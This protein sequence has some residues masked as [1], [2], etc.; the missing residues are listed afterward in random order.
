MGD[1]RVNSKGQLAESSAFTSAHSPP[2]PGKGNDAR[3]PSRC[4]VRGTCVRRGCG[5]RRQLRFEG[6]VSLADRFRSERTAC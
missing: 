4:D 6:E 1:P 5:D 3:D 2:A